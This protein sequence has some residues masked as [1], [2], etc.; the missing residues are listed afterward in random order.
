MTEEKK[1][2]FGDFDETDQTDAD[3][4]TRL[5]A[6]ARDEIDPSVHRRLSEN[7][8]CVRTGGDLHRDDIF[9]RFATPLRTST[10]LRLTRRIPRSIQMSVDALFDLFHRANT[11][12][13]GVRRLNCVLNQLAF[14]QT[15]RTTLFRI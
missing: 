4:Q 5:T 1:E 14:G 12:I 10:R 9:Q 15:F 8:R 2:E 6:D 13:I 11:R 3:P 7:F